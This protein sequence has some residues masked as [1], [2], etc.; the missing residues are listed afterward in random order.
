[1]SDS[2][3][4]SGD[5]DDGPTW[6]DADPAD[7]AERRLD[8]RAGAG[9]LARAEARRD[10]TVRRW[11][12]VSPSATRIGR[13]RAGDADLPERVRRLHDERHPATEG[14]AERAHRLDR[15][16]ITQALCNAL[17]LTRWQRD[18]VLGVMDGL[19]LTAFGSQRAIEKV[20]LVVVRHVVDA[21]RREYLG[22]D[23]ESYVADLDPDEMTD[24]YERFRTLSIKSDGTFERLL[25]QYGLGTTNLNRL[26]NV[27]AEQMDELGLREAV[28]GRN[29]NRDP[30]LP[31]TTPEPAD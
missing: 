30:A 3:S 10:T 20:A 23:D 12:V 19:D 24:L 1:M 27:L 14:H 6:V 5:G 29:P 17:D 8:R 11:D 21:E 18:R 28:F 15:L 7:D 26:D 25:E 16:R 13:A 4:G 2:G 22:L 31:A 9:A